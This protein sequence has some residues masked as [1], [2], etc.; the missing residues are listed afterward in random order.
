MGTEPEESEQ[1]SGDDGCQQDAASVSKAF[2]GQLFSRGSVLYFKSL[3][4]NL[5]AVYLEETLKILVDLSS[6]LR[7]QNC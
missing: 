1:T 2:L 3:C 4:P 6:L 5:D 7:H